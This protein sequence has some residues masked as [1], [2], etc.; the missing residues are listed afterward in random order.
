MLTFL[1][2]GNDTGIGKTHVCGALADAC[3][4]RGLH[5]QVVKAVET[6]VA[7]GQDGDAHH[8]AARAAG[9]GRVEAHTLLTFRRPMAPVAAAALEGRALRLDDIVAAI[10]TLPPCDVR[11]VEGAGGLAVPLEASGADWADLARVLQVDA[12]VLVVEDR[13]GAI[14]QA[15]LLASHARL[16][17]APRPVFHLNARTPGDAAIRASNRAGL[18]DSGLEHHETPDALADAIAGEGSRVSGAGAAATE[19]QRACDR[20]HGSPAP[21]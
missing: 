5:V 1:I 21:H 12:T 3:S 14:N 18:A 11:L 15:R 6:G 13:L 7:P 2:S 8:A 19:H 20:S 16:R 10:R 17:G 4:R 9:P